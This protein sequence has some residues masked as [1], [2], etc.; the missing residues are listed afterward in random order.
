VWVNG[1]SDGVVD[2]RGVVTAT[3]QNG[4]PSDQLISAF[5]EAIA[6]HRNWDREADAV[7][8]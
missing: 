6:K 3:S 2:D 5:T 4:D 1:G 8:A 7:P